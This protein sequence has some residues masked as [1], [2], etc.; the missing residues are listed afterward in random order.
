MAVVR[1]CLMTPE[2]QNRRII[3]QHLE[4]AGVTIRPMLELK[5]MVVLLSHGATGQWASIMPKNVAKSFAFARQ[6]RMIPIIAPEASHI[7]GLVATHREPFTPLVS[8][9]LYQARSL[10]P[11]SLA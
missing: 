10:S 7:V 1:L 4:E 3:H 8:A 11:D 5:S 2:M 6:L 9:L